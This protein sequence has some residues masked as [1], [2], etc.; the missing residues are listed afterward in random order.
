MKTT[1]VMTVTVPVEL[2]KQVKALAQKDGR[3]L[4]NMVTILLQK[5]IEKKQAAYSR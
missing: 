4:S 2:R 3:N 5:G 1:E